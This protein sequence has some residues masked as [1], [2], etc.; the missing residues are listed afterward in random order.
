MFGYILDERGISFQ[1]NSTIE[2]QFLNSVPRNL[3]TVC[4]NNEE[5]EEEIAAQTRQTTRK[6]QTRTHG[7]R[8]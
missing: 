5:E 3:I 2:M 8:N 7:N 6:N 1:C 4:Y